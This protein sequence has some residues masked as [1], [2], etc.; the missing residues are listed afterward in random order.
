M[1]PDWLVLR[2]VEVH[3]S[4]L[5][6]ITHLAELYDPVAVFNVS[7]RVAAYLWLPGAKYIAG[8]ETFVIYRRKSA[9][10]AAGS[11]PEKPVVSEPNSGAK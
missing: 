4:E 3:T 10:P 9:P 1:K 2:P 5:I 8:D 7:D 6:D 11:G